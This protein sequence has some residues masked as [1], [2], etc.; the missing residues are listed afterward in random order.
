MLVNGIPDFLY[1]NLTNQYGE[2][3]TKYIIT[4]K[5]IEFKR[6]NFAMGTDFLSQLLK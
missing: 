4:I 5:P 6:K 1:D 2:D 3:I